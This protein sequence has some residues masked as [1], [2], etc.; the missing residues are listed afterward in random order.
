MATETPLD[1]FKAVLGGTSRA[2]SEEQELEL[3][4]TAD[5]PTQ[6]GKHLKVPMPAR[7]LPA[8][9]V[10]EARG[11]ADGFALRL[12]HHDIA[13]HQRGAP[14]EALARAVFDAVEGARVEALGSRGY[15]GITDNLTHA[16]DVRLRADPITRARTRDEVPLS[17]ALGLLVR[18]ALTGQ[19]SPAAAAPGLALVREWIEQRADLSNLAL[20]LDDQRAFQSLAMKLLEDLELVEGDQA[21]E[22]SDEGGSEDEG[23]DSEQQD[24]G[25]EGENQDGEGQAESEQRGEQRESDDA[26]GE[27]QEQ[28]EESYDDLDGEPGDDGEEGMQPVRPNRPPADWSPQFEYKAWTNQFDEVIAATE[29]C[30]QD[31]LARL[32][33]YLDQQLVPLQAVVSR[34]ANRLQRRLMAQQNRSWDFDQEEGL[35]DAARLARVVINP[36]QSLSY[37][38]EKD[39]EF[40]DTVVT[41]LIDNSGSMRGRP[42]SIAAISADILARTLERCGVKTEILGFTTRAWK[43]GQSRE[44][45]LAAGRPPQPGRLNDIRHIVYKMADEPWRRA[46]NSLGLMMREGL[47][48]ENIDGEALL[49]AHSRLIARPEERRILMVISDGAPVDDSTLSVNSG[50]YLERHLRQVIDWIERRS[51]VELIAIGIGHDVT[52][53]YSRAVTIMDAEQLGGTIIEQLAALFDAE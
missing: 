12:K 7:S 4:F 38:V 24:E 44:T 13:L 17:T 8:D 14:Q 33:G 35:L 39:T 6:S 1:R 26:E 22:D 48:K 9:Q 21:P 25:E 37:K 41:L 19:K 45:W 5:A 3:A 23:T 16:L 34:L 30:D 51:P 11:F 40:K 46:R 2:L 36:M 15:Q 50:S 27:G 20:A 53:Y 18:E 52:R 43:G 10:A 28:G 29:L 49:W 32:R 42:I 47:L 31:E